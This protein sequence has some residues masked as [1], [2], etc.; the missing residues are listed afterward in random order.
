MSDSNK[1]R[2]LLTFKQGILYKINGKRCYIDKPNTYDLNIVYP[3]DLYII[4]GKRYDLTK[5]D[6]IKQIPNEYPSSNQSVASPVFDIAYILKMGAG[7]LHNIGLSENSN[8][9]LRKVIDIYAN[10]NDYYSLKRTLKEL[11]F[12]Q[13]KDGD[14][15]SADRDVQFITRKYNHLIDNTQIQLKL[16]NKILADA[17][18]LDTD[19]LI[20]DSNFGCCGECSKYQG[21]VYSISGNSTNYPKLPDFVF[22]YGAIHPGCRHIFFPFLEEY[23]SN[24]YDPLAT[25]KEKNIQRSNR[26]FIDERTPEQ[27][28]AYEKY[29]QQIQQEEKS[30]IRQ[31]NYYKIKKLFPDKAPKSYSA[32]AKMEVNNT[33]EYNNLINNLNSI[34]HSSNDESVPETVTEEPVNQIEE[35]TTDNTITYKPIHKEVVKKK[36]SILSFIALIISMFGFG[37]ISSIGALLGCIDLIKGKNDGKDHSRSVVAIIAFFGWI[38]LYLYSMVA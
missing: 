36:K 24:N 35:D 34:E 37:F 13:L 5:L 10:T 23:S 27:K 11:Q 16:F 20:L 30:N 17:K 14:I 3:A 8:E 31:I 9:C 38:F 32:F 12:Q 15:D 29:I 22:K 1:T 26:P 19:L 2:T 28:A 4:D 6:D 33:D 25:S 7:H 21:R 18:S